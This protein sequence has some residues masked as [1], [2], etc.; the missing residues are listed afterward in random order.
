MTVQFDGIYTFLM[1]FVRMIAMLGFNPLMARRNVPR[2]VVTGF[3]LCLTLLIAPT[4]PALPELPGLDIALGILREV[5]IGF[6]CGFIFQIFYYLLFF[7]GDF[8]DMQFG[9]SM[10]KMFDPG[11][12]IQASI[13]GNILT[14]LFILYFFATDSHLILL[15]LFASSYQLIPLGVSG[16]SIDGVKLVIEIF[17]AAFSLV[18]H[19]VLPFAVAEYAVEISM[20]VLMK[21][22]PQIHVFVINMQTKIF[23]AFILLILFAAPI[24]SFLDNYI[25]VMLEN[26]Q[27]ALIALS[28]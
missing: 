9:L 11:T 5:F 24:A 20:G 26:I 14:I 19:L 13:S 6:V 17:T 15:K 12:N 8:M 3:A 1:V 22:I 4:L 18:I 10:A 25:I 2:R 7:V 23:V 28:A 16:L 27:R 21:L